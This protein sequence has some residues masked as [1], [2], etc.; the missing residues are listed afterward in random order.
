MLKRLQQN[1]FS[2]RKIASKTKLSLSTVARALTA[3]A[4]PRPGF[5]A[6]FDGALNASPEETIALL[7]DARASQK[8]SFGLVLSCDK[9]NYYAYAARIYHR[10][11]EEKIL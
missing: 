9:G 1:G 7:R 10:P 5:D 6:K 4:D 8:H 3:G 11:C 2:L